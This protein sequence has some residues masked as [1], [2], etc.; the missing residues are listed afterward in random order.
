MKT[1]NLE[2]ID[3]SQDLLTWRGAT[4]LIKPAFYLL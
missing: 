3:K 1:W 2:K 4:Y